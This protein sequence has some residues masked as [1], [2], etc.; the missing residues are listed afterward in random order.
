MKVMDNFAFF[1]IRIC[2]KKSVTL[3]LMMKRF[4]WPAAFFHLSTSR[5]IFVAGALA[6]PHVFPFVRTPHQAPASFFHSVSRR[7]GR[8]LLASR[9]V[10]LLSAHC[11]ILIMGLLFFFQLSHLFLDAAGPVIGH[12]AIAAQGG[13]KQRRPCPSLER[14]TS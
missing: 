9:D 5:P 2:H 13:A 1:K 8:G 3:S 12:V 14:S 6:S 7:C 11:R 10:P 4:F